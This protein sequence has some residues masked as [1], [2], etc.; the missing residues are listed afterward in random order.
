MFIQECHKA[1]KLSH[2]PE[3]PEKLEVDPFTRNP[4]DTQHFVHDVK[5]KLDY[6]CDSLVKEID[7]V[8]L[9]IPLL[10]DTA[11]EW[12]KA[13]HLYINKDVAKRQGIKFNSKN[14]LRTWQGFRKRLEGS[15]GGHLDR[16][17]ALK[18]WSQLHM[19]AG[20]VN[21][22]I[23]QLICLAAVLRYSGKFVKDRAHMGMRDE[24]NAAWSIET[25]YPVTYINYLDLLHQTGHQLQDA[26][27]FCTQ[28]QQDTHPSKQAKSDDRHNSE[29]EKQRKEQKSMW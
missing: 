14:E 28:V 6:I 1:K 5:I 25:P 20:R 13:I 11:K 3:K 15:P 10:K 9:V 21:C 4:K 7:K 12:Y 18:E 22:F 24:L 16:N 29:G 27:N 17:C 19:K 2:Q 23:N 8:S 26:S